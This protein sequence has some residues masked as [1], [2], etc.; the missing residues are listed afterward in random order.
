MP[1]VDPKVFLPSAIAPSTEALNAEI[2]SK[3]S[4]L[5]DLWAIPPAIARENRRKGLGP[6]PLP[7]E[8]PRARVLA[9]EGP[10]GEIPLRIVAPPDPSG[11][12]LHLHGGGWMLGEARLNDA[13]F[14]K[15]AEACGLA[16]V[17]VDYRLAPEDPYPAGPDDCEAAALWLVRESKRQFGTA[18]LMIGGESAGANLSVS[19]LVRLR[20]RHGLTPFRAANLIAGCFD[21]GMT[22]SCRRWG[23]RRLVL[24]TRDVSLFVRTYLADGQ[25]ERDPDV[26]PLCADIAGLPPAHF[27][28]GTLDPL[29]D[30]SLFMAARWEAAGNAARL[31]VWPGGI[32][33]FQGFNFPMAHEAFA[34]EAAFLNAL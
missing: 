1:A 14:D 30:D 31:S 2:V 25:D 34:S 16:T 27:S 11:V 15:L 9:I 33:V 3:L 5:P 4:S 23:Q 26:S 21:L 8:S 29:L 17:S 6:F 19:T 10:R 13:T 12:Y 22:P 28:V 32:H 20:D 7:P 24:D 18:R